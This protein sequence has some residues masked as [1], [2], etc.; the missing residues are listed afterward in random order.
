[1]NVKKDKVKRKI[2]EVVK[3]EGVMIILIMEK[4]VMIV[5]LRNMM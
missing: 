2:E 3:N 1:M 5:G 4:D